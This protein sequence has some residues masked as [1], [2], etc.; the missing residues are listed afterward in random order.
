MMPLPRA[1]PSPETFRGLLPAP[2]PPRPPLQKWGCL[3]GELSGGS[4]SANR[5]SSPWCFAGDPPN[6]SRIC[7][8]QPY[9]CIHIPSLLF[10]P[11]R[12]PRPPRHHLRCLVNAGIWDLVTPFQPPSH[13]SPSSSLIYTAPSPTPTYSK[14]Q[15]QRHPEKARS[16]PSSA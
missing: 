7:C 6:S 13:S 8:V 1:S 12:P 14:G 4:L 3:N 15:E 10:S 9:C 16:S 11:P 5:I 2:P